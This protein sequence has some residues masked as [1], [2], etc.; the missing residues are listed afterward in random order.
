M[1]SNK[2]DGWTLHVYANDK[3][4]LSYNKI[5][6]SRSVRRCA[7][8]ALSEKGQILEKKLLL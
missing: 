2:H 3:V 6:Y 8:I 5:F 1:P 7:F 4:C